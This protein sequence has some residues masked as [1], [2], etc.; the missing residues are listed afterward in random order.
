M[1]ELDSSLHLV[2]APLYRGVQ[3]NWTKRFSHAV[4]DCN[5]PLT[6]DPA[7]FF[8]INSFGYACGERTLLNEIKRQPWLSR[9]T[10]EGQIQLEMI[11]PHGWLWKSYDE[12]ADSFIDLLCQE[13]EMACQGRDEVYLLLSGGLD[14]RVV[15]GIVAKCIHQKRISA[16]VRAVTWGFADCRDVYYAR[17]IAESLKLHWQPIDFG[18]EH[19]LQN[20]EAVA[21]HLGS[22]VS[23]IHLHRIAWFQ[24]VSAEALVL[25]GSYGDMVGRA[26]FSGR[27]LLEYN[28]LQPTNPFGLIDKEIM[29]YAYE[30]LQQDLKALHTRTPD[31]PRHVLCEHE[32]HGHY[33]RGM[34]NQ[35]MSLI[36]QYCTLYQMFTHPKVYSYIWSLHPALRFD[37]I[38]A[39]MLEKLHSDLARFPWARTNR[40]LGGK[41][42]GAR[43]DLRKKF[44]DY[45]TWIAGP[46]FETL[47]TY[48][49]PEWFAETKIF[50]PEKIRE[51]IHLLEH[52]KR[53][54]ALYGLRPFERWLWLA[55]VRRF[56]EYLDSRGNPIVSSEYTDQ[57]YSH[58]QVTEIERKK[59]W[60]L[61]LGKYIPMIMGIY[62][63][64]RNVR[65]NSRK[66]KLRRQIVQDYP[67]LRESS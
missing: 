55:A 61:P 15:A 36:N 32:M 21:L 60:A 44:H 39:L 57:N 42:I 20:V 47:G 43:S 26:E 59:K 30:S 67:P 51:L 29:P 9:I 65:Q 3:G 37:D 40:A 28:Y 48:V 25:A 24:N 45:Y 4:D 1:P 62:R 14:S 34:L 35:A 49:D 66:A 6:W 5:I 23:P 31:Q 52:P 19:V 50:N 53:S 7:A 2:Q 58:V 54:K 33:T 27:H 13:A 11:P 56:A 64:W 63:K 18:P 46:V 10:E 16:Q 17:K 38:Y 12:I 8:S 22:I 41:T